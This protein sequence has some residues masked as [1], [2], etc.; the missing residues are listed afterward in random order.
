MLI[1]ATFILTFL[2]ETEQ[3]FKG[4]KGRPVIW[5]TLKCAWI[6][7]A[8]SKVI[9]ILLSYLDAFENS[10]NETSVY[11]FKGIKVCG[12]QIIKLS[13]IC[14]CYQLALALEVNYQSEVAPSNSLQDIFYWGTVHG[15]YQDKHGSLKVS[16]QIKDY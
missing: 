16:V 9:Y 6:W 11:V 2:N 1:G 4:A 13:W 10:S 12:S 3:A 7:F 8:S 14:L 15:L 5:R